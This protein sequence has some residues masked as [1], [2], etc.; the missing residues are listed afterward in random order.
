LLFPDFNS[1][2]EIKSKSKSKIKNVGKQ[3]TVWG[4]VGDK[5]RIFKVIRLETAKGRG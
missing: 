5:L 4:G 1:Q 3:A 2:K